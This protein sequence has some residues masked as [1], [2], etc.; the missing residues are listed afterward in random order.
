MG[1]AA[2]AASWLVGAAVLVFSLVA[3]PA[4]AFAQDGPGA[5]PGTGGLQVLEAVN[6]RVQQIGVGNTAR[7][8]AWAGVQVEYRSLA[9]D[10]E[11]VLR[12]TG[13]DRDGDTPTYETVVSAEDRTKSAWLYAPMPYSA[14]TKGR[15]FV[16]AH[17]AVEA[18]GTALG[19]RAGDLLSRR[20]VGLAQVMEP[21]IGVIGVVGESPGVMG[22]SEYQSTVSPT[23]RGYQ[24]L[25]HELTRI[26][27]G[28]RVPEL[29]DRWQGLTVFDAIVWCRGRGVET[30]PGLLS[31][32]QA[33]AIRDYVVRGGHLVV[34]LPEYGQEWLAASGNPLLGMLPVMKAPVRQEGVSLE[35]YRPLLTS[36]FL[37]ALPTT[38][39]VVHEL[40]ADGGAGPLEAIPILTG[41]DDEVVVMRR[42]IGSGAVT[43]IG[44]DVASPA[45]AQ[46]GLPEAEAF[47]HRV[48]GRRG[49]LRTA[50][51]L[52]LI[53]NGRAW[54]AGVESGR[55]L[56]LHDSDFDQ[57]VNQS[58]E[59]AVAVLL[60]LVVFVAYWVIA[61]PAG[62]A[63]LKKWSRL[64]HAWMVFLAAVVGFAVISWLGANLIRPKRV[65]GEHLAILEQVHGQATQR[66]RV[67]ASVLIPSYGQA[68]LSIGSEDEDGLRKE[69]ELGL[70]QAWE[71]ADSSGRSFGGFPDNRGYAVS[72]GQPD[73]ISVP[74]RQTVKLVRADWAGEPVA[75]TIDVVGE[76]GDVGDPVLRVDM[77]TDG[78]MT[79]VDGT[80]QHD[81]PAA[82]ENV[83]VW[84]IAPQRSL[85]APLNRARPPGV[86]GALI[87]GPS[88]ETVVDRWEPG[89]RLSLSEVFDGTRARD[90]LERFIDGNRV[91]PTR[92][93]NLSLLGVEPARGSAT[94]R[95]RKA[96]LVHMM[97]PPDLG[98][99]STQ[100]YPAAARYETHGWDVGRWFTQPCVVVVGTLSQDEDE[101]PVP[102]NVNGRRVRSSGETVVRWVYPL[103]GRPPAYP[104]MP[105]AFTDMG[106]VPAEDESDESD[107]GGGG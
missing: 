82:L 27:S 59:A 79:A 60:G 81:L 28:L 44:I 52:K 23:V 47:W 57:S 106:A 96:T 8:G 48:L 19:V 16:S 93:N 33:R 78:R 53:Q 39:S 67:W 37:P 17:D 7:E 46:Q 13:H 90:R 43:V 35:P 51:E 68:T 14:A 71:S 29:P 12:L 54:A 70:I 26:A 38:N 34:V 5:D 66:A 101:L 105:A 42:L 80:L 65:R 97:E 75:G 49:P 103:E 102:L 63:L 107:E 31:T 98:G 10:R 9:G 55:P 18:S 50:D 95:L 76:P 85:S 4:A 20:E 92:S 45:L 94:E 25:G 2:R 104:R 91:T 6:L 61:G 88:W 32:S 84:V 83:W 24:P 21:Q 58:G 77:G 64:Q 100:K 41:P 74:A 1:S 56:V 36:S 72:S 73:A 69:G 87:S 99:Q 11:I 15:L 3:W 22:L 62:Y 40:I 89:Q 86:D 30:D